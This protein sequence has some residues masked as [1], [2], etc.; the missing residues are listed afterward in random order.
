MKKALIAAG[1]IA[2]M[3]A[4]STTANAAC[5]GSGFYQTCSDAQGNH[6][7][8]NRY[9]PTTQMN[10]YNNRTG[11]RWNQTTTRYDSLGITQHS[12]TTN[13]RNW[14]LDEHRVGSTTHYSGRDS[15]G[16]SINCMRSSVLPSLN[17]C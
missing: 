2:F 17:T 1:A 15:H 7:N 10:G 3:G 9:G 12:G 13:G 11:S 8:V 6:Y 4:V 16:N 5:T 14:S